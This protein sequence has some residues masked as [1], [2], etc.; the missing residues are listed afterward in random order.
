MVL[1]ECAGKS[2]DIGEKREGKIGIFELTVIVYD[3]KHDIKYTEIVSRFPDKLKCH[4]RGSERR[5][6]NEA[7]RSHLK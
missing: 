5:R 4:W 1:R 7:D 2:D 3:N 6:V